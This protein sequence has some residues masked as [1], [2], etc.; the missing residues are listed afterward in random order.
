MGYLDNPQE[1]LRVIHVAGTNGKGSVCR[2]LYEMLRA[3]GYRVGLFTSPYVTEFRERIEADGAYISGAN[4]DACTACVLDAASKMTCGGGE[5]PTEF[6]ILT[7]I[8][9]VYFK[10][11]SLDFVVM[12]VGLGG[13]GD[14]TNVIKRPVLSVITNIS[15]DH[16]DRLGETEEMIAAEK[17]GIIKEACPVVTAASGAAAKVIARRAYELGAPLIRATADIRPLEGGASGRHNAAVGMQLSERIDGA[18]ASDGRVG[19]L[20]SEYEGSGDCDVGIGIQP[21]E[22]AAIRVMVCA[23]AIE[24]WTFSADIQSKRYDGITIRMPGAHQ[25]RNAVCA[26]AAIENLRQRGLIRLDGAALRAGMKTARLPGRFE[27]IPLKPPVILDGAHNAAGAAALARTVREML[28]G[29]RILSVVSVLEDKD[30]AA[31][32]TQIASFS[33]T[34]ILTQ[35]G[36]ERCLTPEALNETLALLQ[37]GDANDLSSGV[38]QEGCCP[39]TTQRSNEKRMI[40]ARAVVLAPNAA[41]AWAQAQTRAPDY[42]VV[43]V[44]G[45]LYLISEIRAMTGEYLA[46]ASTL[47]EVTDAAVTIG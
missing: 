14:S 8:A 13:R 31:I 38:P 9:F 11:L 6:E 15:L 42:D 40:Q 46:S 12:E 32:L 44:A 35:S 29:H 30:V 7:A 45:S 17:A 3:H 28:P 5:S 1:G 25:V 27:H 22:R 34:L 10:G 33:E 36:N 23:R 26:L 39:D 18:G 47:A 41:D 2:Y 43:V 21:S 37:S 24:G 4:L 20:S 16:T 19:G